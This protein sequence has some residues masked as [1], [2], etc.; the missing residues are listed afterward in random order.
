M[1]LLKISPI[2]VLAGLMMTGLD[3]LLAAPIATCV[4]AIIAM[5]TEKYS[6]KEIMEKAFNNVR[7]IVVVFFILMFAYGLAESF[8]AT[9]VGASIIN[10]ALQLGV[11]A[12]TVAVVGFLVTCVLSV[13]T[14]TS[15][16]TFAACAPVFLWLN[17]IVG[18]NVVLTVCSI[19]G[20]ACFGD[21]IGLI[22]DTTVLSSGLQKVEIIHRVRHQGVWSGLCLLTT[23]IVIFFAGVSM[24]LPSTVGS[25][26]DAINAIPQE[27]WGAL[28]EARPSAVTL[29]DQVKNGVAVY[30]VIPLI[31]V[32]GMAVKGFQTMIC[33]GA[34]I[35]SS[36]IL[37][38]AAG[39]VTSLTGFL[40]LLYTGFSDAGSWSIVMMM[41]V[42]SFGGIMNSM[43][44]FE[45]LSKFIVN[46]VKNV[47]QLMFS[48]ALLCLIGNAAFG[49]ETAEIVTISPIIKTITDENVEAS[50]E[51]MYKLRLR[52]ATFADALGVYGS[53]L[54]PW[55][56]FVLFYVSIAKAVYPLYNFIPQDI[57]RYNFMAFIAVGSMLILTITGWDRFIPL[58]KL[59]SEPDVIL[60]KKDRVIK[61]V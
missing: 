15:W 51:D 46:T 3:V 29:L 27:A 19:A 20:G 5:M 60:R 49:D 47:K 40:D 24:G 44:A 23:A 10:I 34:G 13:A 22:S 6:F 7:E 39:T 37:G 30:M 38:F 35:L 43:H 50:E 53:Q 59:P 26:T 58:F 28:N 12:K 21:N 1:A 18:G 55:H 52:N 41:W 2:F 48:N 31:I 45:P 54:I 17:H 32:I 42:A 57:I 4:A 61:E 14:G 33:L 8:M 36:L 56:C 9:G 11:T 25:A 16:G